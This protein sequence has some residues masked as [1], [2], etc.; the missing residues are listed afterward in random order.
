MA[1]EL[2]KAV[3]KII[4]PVLKPLAFRRVGK[5][6][7]IRFANGI[8]QRLDFQVT[9]WGGR[10]FCVNVSAN[11]VASNEFVT[12]QPGFRL[13]RVDDG[14]DLWLPSKTKAEAETSAEAILGLIHAEALPFFAKTDTLEGFSALLAREQWSSKHHLIFERGVAAALGG[15]VIESRKHLTKAIQLYEEDGRDWCADYIERAKQL[16][17]ALETG[18]ARPLLDRWE[19]ANRKAQGI[20]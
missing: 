5:R 17:E 18:N 9:R 15:D 20:G 11:I 2:A 6:Q 13:R 19:Q 4:Y 8:A 16:L 7:F 10:D 1:D 14:G 12:L 3:S